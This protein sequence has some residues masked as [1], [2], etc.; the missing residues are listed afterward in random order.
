M[1][2]FTA[3]L[4][5]HSPTLCILMCGGKTG[6]SVGT[7]VRCWYIY[8]CKLW[9]KLVTVAFVLYQQCGW[10]LDI[11]KVWGLSCQYK[12]EIFIWCKF[13]FFGQLSQECENKNPRNFHTCI[14]VGMVEQGRWAFLSS[15][16]SNMLNY[17]AQR[18][19]QKNSLVNRDLPK[20]NL[21]M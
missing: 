14:P 5:F 9:T 3:C 15:L 7:R 18:R 6:V 1:W 20:L 11:W 4:I 17:V 16:P 8:E 21:L 12:N 10:T 19:K 13:C 2:S